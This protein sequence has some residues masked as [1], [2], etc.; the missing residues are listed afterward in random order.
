MNPNHDPR[1]GQ[2]SSGGG[3]AGQGPHGSG[4]KGLSKR[5]IHLVVS[6]SGKSLR[7]LLRRRVTN[8][9]LQDIASRVY[10]DR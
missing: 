3:T 10:G 5:A 7:D 6:K 2:F 9:A 8:P 1:T 4:N